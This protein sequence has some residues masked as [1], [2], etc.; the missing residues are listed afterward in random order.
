MSYNLGDSGSSSKQ[1][2]FVQSAA[3]KL[4][5]LEDES[6]D[7]IVSGEYGQTCV[8]RSDYIRK[9]LKQ[10]IG[11]IGNNYGLKSLA[12]YDRMVQLHFGYVQYI[13]FTLS[14]H[15]TLPSFTLDILRIPSPTI[16]IPNTKDHTLP[17]RNTAPNP[18]TSNSRF[19]RRILGTTRSFNRR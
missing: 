3:E 8:W 13:L 15:L 4:G 19:P 18:N 7:L 1:F 2:E 17:P 14:K 9:Q 16:S 12:S 5:F 10:C 11:L 6:V